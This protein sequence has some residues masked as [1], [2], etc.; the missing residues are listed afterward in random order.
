MKI[1]VKQCSTGLWLQPGGQWEPTLIN[2]REFA[3]S[4]EAILVSEESRLSCLNLCFL[5]DDSELNFEMPA[6]RAF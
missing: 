4:Q 5:F 2:A 1:L 6:R 3:S